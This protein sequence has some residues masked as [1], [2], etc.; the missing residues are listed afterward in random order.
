MT[1]PIEVSWFAALCDDDY[2]FLGVPDPSLRSSWEHCRDITLNADRHG[3]DNILLP[4]GYTLGI[5]SVAFAGGV[6]PLLTQMQLL[7]AVRM[8]ELWLPQLARQLATLDQMLNGRLTINIISSDIPGDKLESAPRYQ[9]TRE[10]MQVLRALL[11]GEDI[12]FHGEFVDLTV[13]PPR[14]RT[15]SGEC[16]LFYFGGFSEDAKE[17]AAEHADVFLTWPDKVD[18]VAG[19]VREMNE[20]AA[21]FDRT[22]RYGFRS[23]VIVR[24]TEAEARAAADRLVSKLD[25]DTGESIRAKSLDA[26]SVGVQRQAELRQASTDDGYVED[27]LWTG[28]GRARSGAGA[29][30]VGDPD[31]VRAKIE[32]Y[33]AVGVDAFIF[34][35]YPHIE[36]CDLFAKYVLPNLNHQPLSQ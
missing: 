28:V 31:Q 23:H 10:W 24:E 36:E 21:K 22:L 8:G 19:L 30:I 4:S 13:E 34:S 7:V 12:D 17:T 26:A 25:T 3:F 5:D 1:Q 32:A 27:N 2:E 11:N 33:Q 18:S 16:P 9:R 29:A 6:A 14:V 15:V 20:R 35:G